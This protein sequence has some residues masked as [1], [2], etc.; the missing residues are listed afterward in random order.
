[1]LHVPLV[2]VFHHFL[3]L[4]FERFE[5][6]RRQVGQLL[7]VEVVPNCEAQETPTVPVVEVVAG[8]DGILDTV[9]G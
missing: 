7:P 1:M 5:V 9:E 4:G 8:G 2:P 3:A 6:L